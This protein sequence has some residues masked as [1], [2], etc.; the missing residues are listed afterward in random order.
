MTE[1]MKKGD[2]VWIAQSVRLHWD[3]DNKEKF[4]YLIKDEQTTEVVWDEKD[5]SYDVFMRGNVW[6]VNKGSTYYVENR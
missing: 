2:L 6:T 4:R 5:K 1:N 3:K